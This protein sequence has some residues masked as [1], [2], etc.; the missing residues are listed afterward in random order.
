MKTLTV[1]FFDKLGASEIQ[2]AKNTFEAKHPDVK[3]NLKSMSHE[4][5]FLALNN[6]EAKIVINDIRDEQKVFKSQLLTKRGLI[7]VLQKG[8]YQAGT[9]MIEKDQ[10]ADLNCFLICSPEEETEELHLHKDLWHIHSP[11]IAVSNYDEAG[12]LISSGSGYFIMNEGTA[13]L[14]SN[15]T[16]Q[17]LFLL[18]NRQQMTQKYYAFYKDDDN[19]IH[20][21][22]DSLKKK[23]ED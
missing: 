17:K 20:E 23:Y 2:S 9:Q 4:A 13:N 8:S 15:D 10:L 19:L 14:I 6:D 11:F 12:V 18:D 7:A 5:A 16:L 3:V 1:A 21:F 22:I